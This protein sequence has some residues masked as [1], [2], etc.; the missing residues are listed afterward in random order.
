MEEILNPLDFIDRFSWRSWLA[1]HHA[2][3]SEA[4][5]IIQKKCSKIEGLSLEEAVEEAICY[6]W[7]DGILRS[8]DERRYLLRFSPRK[9]NS[10][11]SVRN[12]QRVEKLVCLGMMTDAGL[13]AVHKAKKSGQWQAAIER[14]NTDEIPSELETALRRTKGAITAYRKLPDSQKKQYVYW[15]QS[16]KQE[17]T[18]VK[19]IMEIVKQVID[20]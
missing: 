6:G 17:Q 19:R 1:D 18:K 16:A 4:W 7:I 11:W 3:Y 10:V 15:L 13:A 5:L 9:P 14:E 8:L 12:I 2:T 20:G